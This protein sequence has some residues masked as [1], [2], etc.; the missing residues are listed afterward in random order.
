M[1]K[2]SE[3]V[4]RALGGKSK[5]H[6]CKTLQESKAEISVETINGKWYWI[7]WG[8]D[9]VEAHGIDFC[10]YCGEKLEKEEDHES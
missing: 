4:N 10:P 6:E 2:R 7:F 9:P 8:K 3:I 1:S 5:K